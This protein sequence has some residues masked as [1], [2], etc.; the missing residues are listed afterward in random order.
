M[1]TATIIGV[2][3]AIRDVVIAAAL[4]WVGVTLERVETDDRGC[5]GE[6]CQQQ[7]E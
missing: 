5:A 1:L 4:A 3:T 7:A 2:L 6:T